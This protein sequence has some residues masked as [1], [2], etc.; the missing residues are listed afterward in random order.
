MFGN[1]FFL[2]NFFDFF[3]QTGAAPPSSVVPVRL[4]LTEKAAVNL[5]ES[6]LD[7]IDRCRCKFLGFFLFDST[8]SEWAKSPGYSGF[9]GR[10]RVCVHDGTLALQVG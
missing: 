2:E 9:P 8:Y 10:L 1:F 3:G 5:C 6:S 4:C 7:Q